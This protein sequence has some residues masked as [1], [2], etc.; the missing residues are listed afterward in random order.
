MLYYIRKIKYVGEYY[1]FDNSP[2]LDIATPNNKKSLKKIAQHNY[3]L[4]ETE[5]IPLISNMWANV[6]LFQKIT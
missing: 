2:T 1:Y 6:T 3:G 4:R 5:S